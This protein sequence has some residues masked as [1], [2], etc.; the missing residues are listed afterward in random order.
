MV[1]SPLKEEQD[2]YY[3]AVVV[4]VNRQRKMVKLQWPEYVKI[5][6]R[7]FSLPLGDERIWRYTCSQA[8]WDQLQHNTTRKSQRCTYPGGW[9]PKPGAKNHPYCS[10]PV[11]LRKGLGH[12]SSMSRV[13]QST[14]L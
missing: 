10:L 1:L 8:Y 6:P 13:S 7:E 14:R 12:C 3:R 9:R 5:V 11:A 4:F 2:V